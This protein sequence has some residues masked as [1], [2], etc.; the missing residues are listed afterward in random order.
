MKKLYHL[1]NEK[2]EITHAQ[3]FEEGQQ[4]NNAVYVELMNFIKPKVNPETLEVYEG[5]TPEEIAE[6]ELE[7]QKIL[8]KQ[9]YEE[10]LETDWYVVR[11][12]EI[13]VEIPEEILKQR[14]E[15]RDKYK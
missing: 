10:L 14:Q 1:Y 9:Q 2:F 4:P 3:I 5:A 7:Q 8:K 6:Q 12:M 13:G 11:F 15:I